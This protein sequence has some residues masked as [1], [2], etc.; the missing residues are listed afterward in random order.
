MLLLVEV[1]E[2]LIYGLRNLVGLSSEVERGVNPK[3]KDANRSGR[4]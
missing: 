2:N 3:P 4:R 1:A